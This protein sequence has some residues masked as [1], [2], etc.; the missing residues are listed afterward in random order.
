MFDKFNLAAAILA[1][2][3]FGYAQQQG[4]NLFDNVANPDGRSGGSGRVY[5]K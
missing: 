3:L 1:L 4:W 2:S 5:H